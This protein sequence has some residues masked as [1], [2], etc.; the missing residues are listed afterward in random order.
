MSLVILLLKAIFEGIWRRWFGGGASGYFKRRGLKEDS[1][2]YTKLLCSRGTQSFVNYIFLSVCFYYSFNISNTA[3]YWLPNSW[4][5]II[6]QYSW[7]LAIYNG[8]LFQSLY[9]SKGHGPI[10]D[11]GHGTYPPS[12]ETLKR[13]QEMWHTPLFDKLWNKWFPEAKKYTYLYDSLSM[14]IRYTYPCIIVSLTAGWYILPLGLCCTGC[15]A[16]MW[17]ICDHDN[18]FFD[19]TKP[20]ITSPTQAAEILIGLMVGFMI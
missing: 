14:F 1:T 12:K 16:L 10:F 20:W 9:W 3:L 5:D 2:W 11:Y 17:G 19:K 4:Q 15:Y 13:Y 7:I 18:W 6:I 8:F